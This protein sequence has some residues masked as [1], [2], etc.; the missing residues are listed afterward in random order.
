MIAKFFQIIISR[1]RT[2]CASA[3]AILLAAVLSLSA[4]ARTPPF[5]E[6]SLIRGRTIAGHPY[7]NG[8]INSDEQR[9][10][11]RAGESYNL[12]LVFAS[13]RGT[14]ITPAFIVIGANERRHIEKI[15]I[16][17]PWFFIR[18]PPGGYTLLARFKRE[19]VLKRNV[20]LTDQRVRKY[21]LR[22]D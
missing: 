7:L 11:E 15:A 6:I 4:E 5:S 13:R 9:I 20:N 14:L 3:A 12:K 17:A 21:F 1:L 2:K 19:V 18:L 8:G 22:G 10:M 16:R